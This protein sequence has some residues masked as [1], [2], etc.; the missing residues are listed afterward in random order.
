MAS[1]KG[2]KQEW[3]DQRT[4]RGRVQLFTFFGSWMLG[5]GAWPITIVLLLLGGTYRP[6]GMCTMFL[7]V[8][9]HLYRAVRPRAVWPWFLREQ[10]MCAFQ[11]HYFHTQ[12]LIVEGDAELK[13]DSKQLFAFHPHGILC[14]G[15]SLNGNMSILLAKA[16]IY[17]MGTDALFYCPIIS[18]MLTWYNCGPVSKQNMLTR[19]E[20]GENLALIPGG[21]EEATIFARGKHRVFIKQ[22]AGFIKYALQHGY[23][24]RPTYTFGEEETYNTVKGFLKFRMMFNKLKLPGVVFWGSW[25]CPFMPRSDAELTT[26]VGEPLQLPLIEAPSSDQVAEW[27]RK[28]IEAL[29]GVFDRNVGKYARDREAKLELF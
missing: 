2:M 25:L 23:T 9:Y 1:Q 14:C 21:F 7:L 10:Q 17:W 20:S 12:Q 4:M 11:N 29:Q 8:A 19:M 24:L 27:H 28:Y 13:P 18:D 16:K 15:W 22:R 5:A 26:V 6:L 3:K